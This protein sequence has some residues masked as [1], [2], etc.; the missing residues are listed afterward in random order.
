MNLLIFAPSPAMVGAM[1]PRCY[2]PQLLPF[3][4]SLTIFKKFSSTFFKRLQV[5]R[6]AP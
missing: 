2:T 1:A 5:F 3:T 6:A 4:Y